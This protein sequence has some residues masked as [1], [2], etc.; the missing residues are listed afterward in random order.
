MVHRLK[1]EPIQKQRWL[2]TDVT[3]R[4]R[5]ISSALRTELA[6]LPEPGTGERERGYG[7]S[8]N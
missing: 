6:M 3:S 4:L 2:E 7:S 1:V 5:A 8:L